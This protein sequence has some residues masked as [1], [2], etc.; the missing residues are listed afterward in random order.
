MDR[1][2]GSAAPGGRHILAGARQHACLHHAVMTTPDCVCSEIH[3]DERKLT[4]VSAL[5]AYD[6]GPSC[7]RESAPATAAVRT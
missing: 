1:G 2:G 5:V 7:Q 3:G 6:R 4:M